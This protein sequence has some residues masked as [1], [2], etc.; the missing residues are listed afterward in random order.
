MDGTTARRLL[1]V[2]EHATRDDIDRAFRRAVLSAHPDR[3]GDANR[4]RQLVDARHVASATARAARPPAARDGNRF[5][6]AWAA[7]LAPTLSVH[8]VD[9]RRVEPVYTP[10]AETSDFETA[11]RAAL[12]A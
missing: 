10:Q 5:R 1:G 12:A 3:G 2:P 7:P 8:D 11:L 4:F 6:A 9:R